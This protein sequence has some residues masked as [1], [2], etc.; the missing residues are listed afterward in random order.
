MSHTNRW[1]MFGNYGLS[2]TTTHNKVAHLAVIPLRS[3]AAGDLRSW[4]S[5]GRTK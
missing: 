4:Q 2:K 1:S 5:G 3:I